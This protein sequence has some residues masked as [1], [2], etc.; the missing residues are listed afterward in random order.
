M[1]QI[2]FVTEGRHGCLNPHGVAWWCGHE[3][4]I[5]K[6]CSTIETK[7]MKLE[8]KPRFLVNTW[9]DL[10]VKICRLKGQD[11][12]VRLSFPAKINW[13]MIHWQHVTT[14]SAKYWLLLLPCRYMKYLYP[15]EC[16]KRGLSSPG[17]LQAAIDSNRREG[18]RQ[19]YGSAIFNY[20][21]VG[22]PNLLSSP[23][24]Q[25]PHLSMPTH[26]SGHI[27]QVPVIKKG[28]VRQH[29]KQETF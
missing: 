22:T 5:S 2:L 1:L 3:M 29:R 24:I 16:E 27:S 12:I 26:S 23:K 7:I 8:I 14:S 19:S 11:S 25:M 18:R 17:E 13:L 21:P 10:I 6:L 4:I 20:S 9:N 15:Y 28:N